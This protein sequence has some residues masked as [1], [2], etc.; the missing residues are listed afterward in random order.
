MPAIEMSDFE[1]YILNDY[2]LLSHK[3]LDHNYSTVLA[4]QGCIEKASRIYILAS[5]SVT[6]YVGRYI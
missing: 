1:A 3:L 6:V 5:L 2:S 4:F